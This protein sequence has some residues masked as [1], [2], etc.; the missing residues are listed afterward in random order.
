MTSGWQMQ[1]R[2]QMALLAG[3]LLPTCWMAYAAL[4][5]SVPAARITRERTGLALGTLVVIQSSVGFLTRKVPAWKDG[6]QVFHKLA[7]VAAMFVVAAHTGGGWGANLNRALV[8]ALVSLIV[9]AQL[10]HAGKAWVGAAA[11]RNPQPGLLAR[12]DAAANT[13]SG[14]LHRAGLQIHTLLAVTVLVLGAFH[15]LSVYYF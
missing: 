15:V 2:A 3:V 13:E 7:G 5:A 4:H 14:P 6:A 12:L 11:R 10:G 1:P 8:T 9:I